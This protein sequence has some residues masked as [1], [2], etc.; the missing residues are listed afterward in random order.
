MGDKPITEEF[1]SHIVLNLPTSDNLANNV[2][3]ALNMIPHGYYDQLLATA[4]ATQNLGSKGITNIGVGSS[5]WEAQE[6]K[7]VLVSRLLVTSDPVTA[8]DLTTI[9]VGAALIITAALIALWVSL[10][11]GTYSIPGVIILAAL[12]IAGTLTILTVFITKGGEIITN[13]LGFIFTLT[14]LGVGA[15]FAYLYFFKGKGR[16]KAR[17]K[18]K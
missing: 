10:S 11:G 5:R 13:P 2:V 7:C 9:F 4:L 18:K 12:A 14:A 17:G 3:L 1:Q 8:A 16:G 15:Y 6:G